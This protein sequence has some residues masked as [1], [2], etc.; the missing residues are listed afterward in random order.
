MPELSRFFGI[1]I[2][3][4]MEAGIPH[5]TPH[6]HA[7]YQN[8]VAVFSIEPVELITGHLPSKQR[9]FVEAWAELHQAELMN[10]WTKLQT[11]NLPEPI[12]PLH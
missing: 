5:K 1:I 4:Y 3:M 2:R 6:F 8:D 7:H 11:G 9:R 10:D 12:A